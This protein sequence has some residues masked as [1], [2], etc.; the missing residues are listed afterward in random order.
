M[1]NIIEDVADHLC[2]I[3]LPCKHTRNDLPYDNI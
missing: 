1:V 3:L 2:K